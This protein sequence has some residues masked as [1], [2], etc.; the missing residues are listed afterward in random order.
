MSNYA[1]V[2]FDCRA[3]FRHS[4]DAPEVRCATCGEQCECIGYKTPVPRKSDQKEWV[5][6]RQ[7]FYRARRENAQ[8]QQEFLVRK[9]HEL[10]R[11]IARLESLPVNAGRS[12]AVKELRKVL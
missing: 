2:W 12:T 10:E 1:W 8:R 11:E 7:R 9:T 6:L 5:A 3:A 4:P